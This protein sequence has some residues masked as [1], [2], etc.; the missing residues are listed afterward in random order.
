LSV[1]VAE[2]LLQNV[3]GGRAVA[4]HDE[5]AL[6]S[7]TTAMMTMMQERIISNTRYSELHAMKTRHSQAPLPRA[8]CTHSGVTGAI[9]DI[10]FCQKSVGVLTPKSL[11]AKKK[12]NTQN[13]NQI[14]S[15]NCNLNEPDDV[16][17][18]HELP[19]SPFL[20][21]VVNFGQAA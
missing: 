11:T 6:E 8:R 13:P 14:K 1:C 9:L 2:K 4:V 20:A 15:Q 12:L 17:R 16:V 3:Y 19:P 21:F 10:S 5:W 7:A 18:S